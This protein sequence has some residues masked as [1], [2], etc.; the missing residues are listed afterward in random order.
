MCVSA[1]VLLPTFPPTVFPHSLYGD[2]ILPAGCHPQCFGPICIL[3]ILL[4][5]QDGAEG[6]EAP[7][8]VLAFGPGRDERRWPTVGWQ[9]GW[10]LRAGGIFERCMG[11]QTSQTLF[12][13]AIEV[14]EY[15]GQGWHTGIHDF[16]AVLLEKLQII[17]TFPSSSLSFAS[18]KMFGHS[19]YP[20]QLQIQLVG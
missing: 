5:S 16:L 18:C 3:N 11:H 17:I 4:W 2:S 15:E 8:C 6:D 7:E 13:W 12:G 14:L 19:L 10:R 20:F 9:L 1:N